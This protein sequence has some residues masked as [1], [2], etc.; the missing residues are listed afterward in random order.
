MHDVLSSN[1]ISLMHA[2]LCV[3]TDMLLLYKILQNTP[4]QS[5]KNK[6]LSQNF[7]TGVAYKSAVR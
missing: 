3:S 2:Y 7:T 5:R 1:N 4:T 6:I